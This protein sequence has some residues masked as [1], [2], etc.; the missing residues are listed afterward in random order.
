[1][2]LQ[3]EKFIGKPI[4]EFARFG[5]L[6]KP[7]QNHDFFDE[8]KNRQSVILKSE[9]AIGGMS[10]NKL[11]VVLDDN[12]KIKELYT[13]FP[14]IIGRF[15]YDNMITHYGLPNTILGHDK[16]LNESKRDN[17]YISGFYQN[18]S[19]RSYSLKEV[20]F[21]EKPIIII[22]KRQNFDIKMMFYYKENATQLAF[23]KPKEG[24]F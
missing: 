10:Y 22:W 4:K 17:I 7:F 2:R 16:I 6:E 11:E 21:G 18:L 23:R 24:V 9:E 5:E 14:E 20:S 12:E 1:M 19:K 15:F 13:A 3:L 8:L